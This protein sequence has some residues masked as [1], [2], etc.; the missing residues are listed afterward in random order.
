MSGAFH[1][2]GL[3]HYDALSRAPRG[4]NEA[5]RVHI[6]SQRRGSC[7]AAHGTRAAV[8]YAG[9]WI[10]EQRTAAGFRADD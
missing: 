8:D 3:S 6:A 1:S 5:A 2:R 7:M 9:D 10:P 4:G